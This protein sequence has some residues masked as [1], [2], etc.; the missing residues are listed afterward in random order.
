MIIKTS[1]ELLI[2][3]HNHGKVREIQHALSDLPIALRNLTDFPAIKTIEEV[4]ETYEGNASLKALGYAEQTG[5]FALGDDSG[6]EV[7]AL[8]GKPGVFSARYGGEHASDQDRT[9]KLLREILLCQPTDR[10]ARF[11]CSMALAGWP[12]ES[13][14]RT[15]PPRILNVSAGRCDGDIA[16]EPRGAGGFGYDP[17]FI[18][19]GY[20]ES[21]GELTAGVKSRISHRAKALL[22]TRAFLI[23]FLE[24]T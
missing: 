5:L 13:S 17:I 14:P 21:F 16:P 3:T 9:E 7:D 2:A 24:Q 18:P 15:N 20:D 19:K 12:D 23:Q 10:T 11:V 6:L 4:A 1:L 8:K 22:A